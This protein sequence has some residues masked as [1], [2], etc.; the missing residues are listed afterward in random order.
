MFRR[1]A[2]PSILARVR[3]WFWPHGGWWRAV[4]YLRHRLSRLPDAPHRIARGVF[5]GVLVCFTPLFGLHFLLAALLARMFRGNVFAALAATLVGNPVTFPLIAL[6]ALRTGHF[7]LG[8]APAP[9]I[10]D[11]LGQAFSGAAGMLWDNILALFGPQM[12]DWSALAG[13][14]DRVFLPYLV[15]GMLPGLVVSTAF[16]YLALLTIRAYRAHR[17]AR[18]ARRRPR[19]RARMMAGSGEGKI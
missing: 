11:S 14:R 5:F 8:T 19:A 15:G 12:A 2:R 7:L 9:G 13:F 10:E 17:A 6:S 18:I 3:A 16:F 1:R 4:R